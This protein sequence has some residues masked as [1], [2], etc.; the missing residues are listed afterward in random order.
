MYINS[1]LSSEKVYKVDTSSALNSKYVSDQSN[2]SAK[3]LEELKVKSPTIVKI[4]G[5]QI[6]AYYERYDIMNNLK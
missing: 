1:V 3:K 6:S 5:D 2:K 4:N